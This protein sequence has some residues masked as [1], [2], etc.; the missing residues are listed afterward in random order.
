MTEEQIEE[1]NKLCAKFIG[2]SK[3]T[4][5]ELWGTDEYL[6]NNPDSLL[7]CFVPFDELHFDSNWSWI[8]EVINKIEDLKIPVT[9]QVNWCHIQKK[10]L[11]EEGM[12]YIYASEY[13][14]TK[15]EAVRNAIYLFLKQ[16]NNE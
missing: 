6:K 5:K 8:M 13:D 4:E 10:D 15:I 9:I 14:L 2:L 1:Y 16:Y 7:E 11:D 12:P 3:T